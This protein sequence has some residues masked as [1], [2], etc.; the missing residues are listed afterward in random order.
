MPDSLNIAYTNL[1][2][3]WHK[4]LVVNLVLNL[5]QLPERSKMI[6]IIGKF[7]LHRRKTPQRDE[8]GSLHN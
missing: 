6:R 2:I 7:Y 5:I 1:T 4:D 8:S 3:K